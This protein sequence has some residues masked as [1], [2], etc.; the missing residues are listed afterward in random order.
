LQFIGQLR[1]SGRGRFNKPTY[2]L[3]AER[4]PLMY[5]NPA[6]GVDLD[7][8]VGRNV[9]LIGTAAYDGELRANYMVVTQIRLVQ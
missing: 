3:E 9:E 6:P 7:P 1:R 2:V 4:G 5:A 8:Y